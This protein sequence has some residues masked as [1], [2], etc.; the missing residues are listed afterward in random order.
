MPDRICRSY[1]LYPPSASGTED[2]E[3]RLIHRLNQIPTSRYD[4]VLIDC[5]PN[6]GILTFNALCASS[7]VLIPIEP[8]FF[9]LHGLA[10]I[11]ETI[12][13]LKRTKEKA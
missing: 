1:L 3:D 4:F 2:R 6:L 10:K 5:P 7:E 13:W 8:S 11:S 12:D 9:S